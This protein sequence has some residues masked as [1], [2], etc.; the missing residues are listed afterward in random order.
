MQI[1]AQND[2]KSTKCTILTA[3]I[4]R[5]VSTTHKR[6]SG[7]RTASHPPPTHDTQ[8]ILPPICVFPSPLSGGIRG[9]IAV[10]QTCHR[11][12]RAPLLGA[13]ASQRGGGAGQATPD[14]RAFEE[15][16]VAQLNPRPLRTPRVEPQILWYHTTFMSLSHVPS[17]ASKTHLLG[18]HRHSRRRRDGLR[19]PFVARPRTTVP[20]AT[21]L[22]LP[23]G[24]AIKAPN[25]VCHLAAEA[26][27]NPGGSR[28]A[29]PVEA[30][31]WRIVRAA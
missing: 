2:R 10:R 28:C 14:V 23:H 17:E 8:H 5:N 21:V 15:M 9:K 22:P 29:D 26:A 3:E 1:Y 12:F 7:Q 20:T 31:F 16:H 6:C 19:L 18:R 4:I 11:H 25:E 24:I 27:A 30:A 13:R